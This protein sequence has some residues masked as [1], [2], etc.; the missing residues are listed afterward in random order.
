MSKNEERFYLNELH[1]YLD[2]TVRLLSKSGFGI[3]PKIGSKYGEIWVACKLLD[4]DPQIG[5]KRKKKSADIYLNC[6][7]TRVEVK[8]STLK[9]EWHRKNPDKIKHKNWGWAFG[10]GSQ[11]SKNKFDFCVLL[12]AAENGSIERCFIIPRDDFMGNNIILRENVYPEN[13]TSEKYAIALFSQKE[14]YEAWK[15]IKNKKMCPLEATLNRTSEKY[16]DKSSELT[17]LREKIKKRKG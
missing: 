15:E 7:G 12:A 16:E 4:L 5:N 1:R 2:K 9:E 6:T 8:Y 13:M 11:F 14:D 3:D 10:K 17:K